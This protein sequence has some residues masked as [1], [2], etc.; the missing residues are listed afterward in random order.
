MKNDKKTGLAPSL[1][2]RR[3]EPTEI[4]EPNNVPPATEIDEPVT[5]TAFPDAQTSSQS[6]TATIAGSRRPGKIFRMIPRDKATI[7]MER[8]LNEQLRR[9]AA[10]EGRDRSDV[11][12]QILRK[13]L[14]R[15]RVE[16]Q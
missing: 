2:L 14:P 1:L 12:N 7:Y 8:D 3:T 4:P 10:L 6:E 15:Y 5:E 11:V 9:V 16:R 13:H